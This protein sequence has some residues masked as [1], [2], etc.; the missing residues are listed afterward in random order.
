MVIALILALIRMRA[1]YLLLI[2][3]AVL[4]II[5]QRFN[6]VSKPPI[7]VLCKEKSLKTG[8]TIYLPQTIILIHR[9]IQ[10]AAPN[11]FES[12]KREG[13]QARKEDEQRT[14]YLTEE[15]AQGTANDAEESLYRYREAGKG[16]RVS[17]RWNSRCDATRPILF[18]LSFF[19][20]Y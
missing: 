7:K 3:N 20:Y 8:N 12:E 19:L 16:K 13:F 5:Q 10:A 4:Y 14:G 11:L 1:F 2:F 6:K 17:Y 9:G 15:A 18:S